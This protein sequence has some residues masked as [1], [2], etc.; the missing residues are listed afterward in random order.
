MVTIKTLAGAAAVAMMPMAG[1]AATVV[2]DSFD[3]AQLAID[4]AGSGV[5]A[6]NSMAAG[7]AIGGTRT[8]TA[9]G[10]GTLFPVSTTSINIAGGFAEVSNSNNVNGTGLFE[11]NAGGA[12]LTDGGLNDTFVLYVNSTDLGTQFDLT[13]DGVTSTQTASSTGNISF[14][15]AGFGDLSSASMISLLVSGPTAFDSSFTLLGA[16]DL[17]PNPSPVPLPASGMMLGGLMLGAGFVARR[18]KS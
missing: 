13:V 11:W 14:S 7:E 1:M 9:D 5:S 15:F 17:E 10:N 12:D 2:I 16:E 8:I 6:S 4:P 18:R 3:T